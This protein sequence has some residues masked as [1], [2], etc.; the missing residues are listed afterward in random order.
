MDV[1]LY[2]GW[3]GVGNVGF[4]TLSRPKR[5]IVYLCREIMVYFDFR[6]LMIIGRIK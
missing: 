5:K 3:E 6:V 1:G 4:W 2:C